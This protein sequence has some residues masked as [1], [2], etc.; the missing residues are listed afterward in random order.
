MHL[1]TEAILSS[2]QHMTVIIFRFY[3]HKV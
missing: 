1:S 2:L 3:G